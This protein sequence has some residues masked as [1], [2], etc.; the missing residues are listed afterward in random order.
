MKN[1][2]LIAAFSIFALGT[3]S[4]PA[5][6]HCGTCMGDAPKKCEKSEKCAKAKKG[7]CEKMKKDGKPCKYKCKKK[8]NRDHIGNENY[9]G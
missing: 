4:T 9:N 6:A 3:L 1:L 5:Y 8:M 2:L 7:K